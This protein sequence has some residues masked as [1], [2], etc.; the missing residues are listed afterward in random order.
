M[1]RISLLL[2][3]ISFLA[4]Q[5]ELRFEKEALNGSG[6]P[7]GGSGAGSNTFY[8]RCKV[9][10]NAKTFNYSNAALISDLGTGGKNITFV[11]LANNPTI[12]VEGIHIGIY[13]LTGSPTTGTFSQ[14]DVNANYVLTGDYNP[15]S[16]QIGYFPGLHTPSV[17]PLKITISSLSNN[18]VKGSFSGAFY[19]K[20]LT[21]GPGTADEYIKFTE[22][23]FNLPIK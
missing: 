13:F 5:K 20:D 22:G 10:G 16:V 2:F 23:E 11:G 9:D 19:K 15:N 12:S 14:E 21:I 8:M 7:G 18:V 3:I 6:S 17:L 4:C 1:K